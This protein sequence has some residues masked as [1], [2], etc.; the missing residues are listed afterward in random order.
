MTTTTVFFSA[1]WKAAQ[2]R[3][4]GCGHFPVPH[5]CRWRHSKPTPSNHRASGTDGRRGQGS[6]FATSSTNFRPHPRR[7]CSCLKR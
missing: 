6:E 5:S 7:P 3:N 1:G 2:T 4:S